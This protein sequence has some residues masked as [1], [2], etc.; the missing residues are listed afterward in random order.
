MKP[1]ATPARV[2]ASLPILGSVLLGAVTLV[3]LAAARNG[4]I[5]H[6]LLA[7]LITSSGLF[8]YYRGGNWARSVLM[9]ALAVSAALHLAHLL[10]RP[11]FAAGAFFLTNASLLMAVAQP[12]RFARVRS[13]VPQVQPASPPIEKPPQP[14]TSLV[15]FLSKPREMSETDLLQLAGDAWGGNYAEEVIR[16]DA[17]S[18]QV[19]SSLGLFRI[20]HLETP[21][22]PDPST[23]APAIADPAR[24]HALLS[25]RGWIGVDLIESPLPA[26]SSLVAYGPVIRLIVELADPEDTVAIFR[27]ETGQLNVWNDEV[28]QLLVGPG[29]LVNFSHDTGSATYRVAEDDSAF[30]EAVRNAR[31]RFPEFRSAFAHRR[32]GDLF[33]VKAMVTEDGKSEC[34]WLHV[35]ALQQETI[36]GAL[37]NH[38]IELPSLR[39]G[40]QVAVRIADLHD[41][42]YRLGE[43]R[44]SPVIGLFTAGSTRPAKPR[45]GFPF[46]DAP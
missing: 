30:L 2:L 39:F 37:A 19:R 36:Q 31:S 20:H 25:H 33:T 28:F 3:W 27:P 34:I 18:F 24:R 38:P 42:A 4:E 13:E 8:V 43:D 1:A 29:G 14:L 22:W 23:V 11:G 21:Y 7:P 16:L 12:T 5:G 17:V 6:F 9:A 35:T 46:R 32:D 10:G 45:P 40:S 15:L 44:E 41:W 26:D